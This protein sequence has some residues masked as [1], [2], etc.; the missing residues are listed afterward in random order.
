MCAEMQVVLHLKGL[1]LMSD[2]NQ[3]CKCQQTELQAETHQI[4]FSTAQ[5]CTPTNI[6]LLLL[7]LLLVQLITTAAAVK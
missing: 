2:F 7:L 3:N 6:L 1:L 4:Y 5:T